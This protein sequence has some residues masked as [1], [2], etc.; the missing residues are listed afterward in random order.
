MTIRV[1]GGFQVN[2]NPDV[3]Y[4]GKVVGKGREGLA[5]VLK[6]V[7][8]LPAES[9]VVWG[10]EYRR[11][12]ACS[13]REKSLD[14]LFPAE[15]GQLK[16]LAERRKLHLSETY[17]GPSPRPV[18]TAG[19][20]DTPTPATKEKTYAIDW[21]NYHGPGTPADEVLYVLNGQFIGRGDAA[22]RKIV[23]A[24]EQADQGDSLVYPVYEYSGRWAVE[25]FTP[26]ELDRE[27]ARLRELHPLG[28]VRDELL[29]V[30]TKRKLRVMPADVSPRRNAKTVHDWAG[31]GGG[32]E[33]FVSLGRIIH[34]DQRPSPPASRLSWSD[35]ETG[36]RAERKLETLA[37]YTLD[38]RPLGKGVEGF[39]V[40]MEKLSALPVG[41]V[42]HVRTCI[43]TKPDFTCPITFEGRRHFERTGIEPWAGMFRWLEAVALERKL[44][45]EW[46]PDEAES[47]Q[48]CELNK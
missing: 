37:T 10:P 38:D 11:C 4:N 9:S 16:E 34:Y 42:V 23:A 40:A 25:T 35:Y 47:F 18:P 14:R 7:A 45:I 46:I 3:F 29:A 15:W 27:N 20:S 32:P 36:R 39:A 28:K 33:T 1:A 13:G 19:K 26:E 8:V 24:V 41:S 30:A 21:D 5:E 31:E 6:R 2:P 48:A 43:R 17:P 12:G 44:A 22:L